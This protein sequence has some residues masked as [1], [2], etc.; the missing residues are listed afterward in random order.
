VDI[1]P[2]T[3]KLAGLPGP[4]TKTPFFLSAKALVGRKLGHGQ[5]RE[6]WLL[7]R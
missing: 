7:K 3:Q 2:T 5:E 6:P 1:K 4:I